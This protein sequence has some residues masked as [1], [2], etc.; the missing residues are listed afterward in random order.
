MGIFPI[1][2]VGLDVFRSKSRYW[3]RRRSDV[4]DFFRSKAGGE[5]R[6]HSHGFIDTKL[7]VVVI[8]M[9]VRA[10]VCVHACTS[11]RT[12]A[13]EAMDISR[14]KGNVAQF[15]WRVSILSDAFKHVSDVAV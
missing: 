8:V 1:E 3:W 15:F 6:I 7:W 11:T 14:S 10:C 5:L 4:I 2:R 13:V 12:Y 9:C